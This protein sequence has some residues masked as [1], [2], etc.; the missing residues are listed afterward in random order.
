MVVLESHCPC[1]NGSWLLPARVG[2]GTKRVEVRVE[3]LVA[4]PP[5]PSDF[6]ICGMLEADAIE[7]RTWLQAA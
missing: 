1:G 6:F 7:V 2:V 3:G 5:R 4:Q